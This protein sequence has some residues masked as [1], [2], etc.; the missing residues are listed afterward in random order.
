MRIPCREH[1]SLPMPLVKGVLIALPVGGYASLFFANLRG[2][3]AARAG[4]RACEEQ[5]DPCVELLR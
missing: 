5:R 1:T 2:N 3:S 4:L